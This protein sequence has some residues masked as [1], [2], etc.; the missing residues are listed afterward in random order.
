MTYKKLTEIE[1]GDQLEQIFYVADV[2]A[3]KTKAQKPFTILTVKDNSGQ[4]EIKIW[5][6]D[7]T[8]N[9]DLKPKT[10]VKLTCNVKEYKGQ[11]DLSTEGAP[12]IVPKPSDISV[13]M[14]GKGLSDEEIQSHWQYLLCQVDSIENVYLK[15]Y[16][17]LAMEQ[18]ADGIKYGAASATNR[19]AY[20]GGL[21]EHFAKVMR[22]A[23]FCR[24][25][26]LQ[27]KY[28]PED[29]NRDIIITAVIMHD[30]GKIHTYAV[31]QI[32]V[33]TTRCGYLIQH[34]PLSYAI[35]THTWIAVESKLRRAVPEELKDHVN[36]CILAHH[37]LLEYGSPVKPATIEAYIVH[38]A[39]MMDSQTSNYAENS[40]E[41]DPDE[42]GMVPGSFFSNRPLF[43]FD[44]G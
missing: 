32:E 44:H 4:A 20:R 24:E 3:R 26:Q 37:G 29:I 14:S 10:F 25:S 41:R 33:T 38:V 6:F 35:S 39:D 13:Y 5:G 42:H 15:A 7:S 22:N 28:R 40:A 2:A 19:G 36:H 17:S 23:L 11:P 31:D 8:L 18:H 34:L 30:I 12:M 1:V 9:P 21:V 43:T 27:G 16:L